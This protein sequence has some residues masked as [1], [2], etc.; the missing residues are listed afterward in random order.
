MPYNYPQQ[1]K[2]GWGYNAPGYG[3]NWGGGGWGGTNRP[4]SSWGQRPQQPPM[5]YSGYG[6]T[7]PQS[8]WGQPG[9][10]QRPYGGPRQPQQGYRPRGGIGAGSPFA[11]NPY[12]GLKSSSDR[13]TYDM[14][15]EMGIPKSIATSMANLPGYK[16]KNLLSASGWGGGLM[17]KFLSMMP[18]WGGLQEGYG[19]QPVNPYGTSTNHW[20]EGA[21]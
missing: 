10:Y 12:S 6:A 19:Q 11:A 18:G 1:V 3:G 7:Y 4:Q 2:Q 15:M 13:G 16:F 8:G 21:R 14:M 5:P 9:G 17:E 20:M